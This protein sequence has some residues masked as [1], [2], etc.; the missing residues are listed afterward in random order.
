MGSIGCMIAVVEIYQGSESFAAINEAGD[1]QCF[2]YCSLHRWQ[3]ILRGFS[4]LRLDFVGFLN[5]VRAKL[6][7]WQADITRIDISHSQAE[8]LFV[9]KYL[10]NS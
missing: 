1:T 8:R 6:L 5:T 7:T 9:N 3:R 2:M 10:Q 4:R